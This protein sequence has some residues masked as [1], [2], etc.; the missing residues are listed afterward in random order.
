MGCRILVATIGSLGD[1]HPMLAVAVRLRLLGAEVSIASSGRYRSVCERAGCRFVEIGSPAEYV[2]EIGYRAPMPGTQALIDVNKRLNFD[3][4]ERLYT[5]LLPIAA[6]TDVLVAPVHMVVAH[7][8]AERL[9]IPFVAC[10]LSPVQVEPYDAPADELQ[11]WRRQSIHWHAA[12]TRLREASGLPR[13]ILPYSLIVQGATLVLGLF[14]KFLRFDRPPRV[15]VEVVGHAQFGDREERMTDPELLAFCDTNTVAFSFG[16]FADAVSAEHL[17]TESVAACR[18]LGVKCLYVSRYLRQSDIEKLQ[19]N[20]LRVRD[21]VSHDAMFPLVGAVVH[22]G[23]MGT[24][25][26]ACR[27]LKPMVIVPF[28]LDQP[29]HAARMQRLAG[30]VSVPASC[31]D[32]LLVAQVLRRT[33]RERQAMAS[34]LAALTTG[35]EDGAEL[36]ARRILAI[37]AHPRP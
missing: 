33:L 7:L 30:T 12:L 24:L 5:Q 28:F 29:G 31:Y 22:H 34:K 11:A 3:N 4:L 8:V 32:R 26:A 18:M 9:D 2:E 37:G 20:D 36:A 15:N 23:G 35:C 13:R 10:A 14:P 1:L 25:A 6:G 19:G 27:H 17:A 21:Y 16:S